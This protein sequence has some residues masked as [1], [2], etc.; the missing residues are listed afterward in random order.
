MSANTNTY[1]SIFNVI[2][3]IRGQKNIPLFIHMIFSPHLQPCIKAVQWTSSYRQIFSFEKLISLALVCC[4]DSF[5]AGV[6][7]TSPVVS[8]EHIIELF[9]S[10]DWPTRVPGGLRWSPD[11]SHIRQ[12]SQS[13]NQL[14][15]K[16]KNSARLV[17]SFLC[18]MRNVYFKAQCARQRRQSVTESETT[19]HLFR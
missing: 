19:A 18:H 14:K 2:A 6:S 3:I 8:D 7:W 13:D 12:H 9:G 15:L 16:H 4:V 1:I 10:R 5:Y 17:A 11:I